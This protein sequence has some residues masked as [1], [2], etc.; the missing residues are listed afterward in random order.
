[1]AL[2]D[3]LT[4]VFGS[5]QDSDMKK[6]RPVLAEVNKVWETIRPL[7][8]E[9]LQAKTD[10]FRKRLTNGETLDDIMFE[11]FSVVR[12]AT[13]R[14]LGES[15]MV[16]DAKSG[17][18]IPFMA[19]FDVQVIAAVVLHKG[20]IAEMK[21]GEGKTQVGP[22]AAYLNALSGK[23]VHVITVN[24]YLA[25]RDSAWMAR[26]FEFLGMSVGCLDNTAPGTQSRRE[27]YACDITYGTNN[28]FGFDYLRDNMATDKERCVQGELNFAIIDEVDNIL[29]D[30]A[31]T[32]LIISGAAEVDNKEYEEL[33]PVVAKLEKAQN[34]LIAEISAKI[35][36]HIADET[37]DDDFGRLMLVLKLGDPKS[38]LYLDTIK[39]NGV[40]KI[41][42]SIEADY[43]REKKLNVL[44]EELFYSIDEGGGSAE[45]SEMGRMYVSN[46]DPDYFIVPDLSLIIGAINDDSELSLDEKNL[47]REEAHRSYADKAER[48]H[49]ISQLLRAYATFEIDVNYV[50]KEGKV[51]IV[52]EFTGRIL[53]GRRY[54]EGL[55]QALEA[56]EGVSI[57]GESQT[58]ATITFQNFFKMYNKISGM[59]GTAAT[60]AKEFFD[61]YE[62]DVVQIPT[63]RPIA[64][65][66][67]EDLIYRTQREK[68]N[69][70]IEELRQIQNHGAPCLVGTVSIDSSELIGRL[71]SKEGIKHEV[72]NA[73]NHSREAS[74]VA[75]AGRK[76][77]ITIATNMA[78]RGTDI[79]LGGNFEALCHDKLMQEGEDPEDFT[80]SELVDRFPELYEEILKEHDEVL[81]LGGL[82]VL[83]TERHES[84]RIDNQ[85]RG[86]SGRQGDAGSSQFY[87]SL[88]D[89]LMRIFG[90]ER[91]ANVMGMLG[92]EEGEVISH[93]MV[94]RSIGSAQR[95][96]EGRNFEIRKQLKEYDDV[97][98][99]QR[100]QIYG[101]RQK[102]LNDE[103][104][105]DIIR[106]EQFASAL[107]A[108]VTQHCAG[109]ADSWDYDALESD[110][111]TSF[112][113]VFDRTPFTGVGS[114]IENLFDSLW[115]EVIS[116]Y[117]QKEERIGAEQMRNLE[118]SAL[119][120]SIDELW[121]F[122]LYEMD[123]L[124]ESVR[125]RS[126]AQKNPLFEYQREGLELF[127]KL[128]VEI[129]KKVTT[130]L[131]RFEIVEAP[132]EEA[133]GVEMHQ[134]VGQYGAPQ[135]APRGIQQQTNSG[136]QRP[137]TIV[138]DL[139][140]V[141]RNDDCPCGSGKKYKKCHGKNS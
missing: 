28:E 104:V 116:F 73:K 109:K 33:Q 18:E 49:C 14:I 26:I 10:E 83:G 131:F 129:A 42:R 51:Q 38:Q 36:K 133:R 132:R 41:V 121:K 107:E 87:L 2:I 92:A 25:R 67:H 106:K 72:L 117:E 52:D 44:Q 126:Y 130:L 34:K 50:V 27:A 97:M 48:L 70:V 75:Q 17:N 115:K 15:K 7:T 82:H 12:E 90:S 19:H 120:L 89:D 64:R 134:E 53:D 111:A 5:K 137:T 91:I 101:L 63:N 108:V 1:M 127:E 56:K 96:V 55:H 76:G 22:M 60:E 71:L 138:R 103:S 35:K 6:L 61:I 74:I 68:Y 105:E 100:T 112:G 122:H 45:M 57:A 123:Q 3:L 39:E 62:L 30:E 93:G 32:P 13:H 136:P 81:A 139:P 141:G 31:R 20:N 85:L 47:A 9:Q 37:Y 84:R 113:I 124:R 66:D 79:K 99:L 110:L 119:L 128:L 125:F 98:N 69:A 59:T 135:Q 40:S 24:D 43:L 94:S 21:T 58:L 88:D 65:A 102:V 8:D 77:A 118:R 140:K 54:S 11:A 80:E 16:V 95:K 4:K 78:G 23:G 46:N 114:T 86:R 29:I